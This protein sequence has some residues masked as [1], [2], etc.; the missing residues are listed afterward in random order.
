LASS[1]ATDSPCIFCH[2]KDR[3]CT[4]PGCDAPGYWIQVHHVNGW[5][6]TR[7]TVINE[8][9]LAWGPENRLVERG[10]FITRKTPARHRP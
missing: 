5:A 4:K 3:G 10:G 6:G 7:R 8:L 9:T 2:A 1:A